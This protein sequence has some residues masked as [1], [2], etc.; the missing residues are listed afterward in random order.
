PTVAFPH[1]PSNGRVAGADRVK[2]SHAYVGSCTNGRISDLREVARILKGR[3][4]AEGVQMLVVPA[5]QQVWKQAAQEG[6]MEIFVDAGVTVSYPSCGACLGMHTGV[7]GP[8]DVC[9]SST[10]RNFVG[11]IGDPTAEIYLASPATVAASAIA[12]YIS[13]PREYNVGPAGIAAPGS[14][15]D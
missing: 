5:T 3:T 14:A 1:I 10:N 4:V 6:L 15:A 2:V 13:D 9:I 8:G 7:L 11:R 12:G